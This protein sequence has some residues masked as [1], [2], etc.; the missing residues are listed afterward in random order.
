ME[1]TPEG[2]IPIVDTH[3]HLWDLD[4][5]S[6]PW[7]S[8]TPEVLQQSYTIDTY[9]REARGT[10]IERAVYMEVDVAASDRPRERELV[11]E[12]CLRP[13]VPTAAA[14]FSGSVDATGFASELA[15]IRQQESCRG[16]RHLLHPPTI[17][18]GTLLSE[19]FAAG[20]AL[21]ADAGLLFDICIRPRELADAVEVARRCPR[22]TLILDHC[23]N[24][25][26]YIV[27][28]TGGNP[29]D[30]TYG[31]G[32]EQW[33]DDMQVLGS[34]PNVVCKISGVVARAAP[35]WS[36]ADL[37]PA[38]NH[39]IDCFGED[40]IV[41]GSDWPVCTFAASLGEWITALREIVSGRSERLQHKLLHENAERIYGLA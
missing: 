10:G 3:Q 38:V 18:P 26:P 33:L 8:Q 34:L 14:V 39:C 12:L 29:D 1:R 16:I 19:R 41:F 30:P 21:L 22:N 27:A 40:R 7:L 35:G 28:G 31:H 6:P 36:A 4:L 37:A 20:L 23:G 32:R 17:A 24:A 15:A 5:L 2:L 11:A 9:L 13:E 25:D